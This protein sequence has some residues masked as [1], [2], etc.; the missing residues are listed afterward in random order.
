M[1]NFESMTADERIERV[2]RFASLGEFAAGIARDMQALLVPVDRH[3][4][5]LSAETCGNAATQARLQQ[6][7]A[8]V[9]LA[10]NLAHQV[11]TFSR[12][13]AGDCRVIS[14]GTVV[15]D[16]LPLVRAAIANTTLL[17]IAV[18]AQAP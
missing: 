12:G 17:R 6:I 10:R 8:A 11:L 3:A 13:G 5:A 18:D 2:Q 15:R 7:L 4:L 16:A 14:L 9:A 1:T